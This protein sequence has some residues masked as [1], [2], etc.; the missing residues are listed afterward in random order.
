MVLKFILVVVG[1]I[2]SSVVKFLQIFNIT[3]LIF[4]IF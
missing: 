4:K 1:P 3:N 2:K